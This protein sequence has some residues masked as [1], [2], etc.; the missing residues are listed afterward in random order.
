MQNN[1]YQFV[2]CYYNS[3]TLDYDCFARSRKG[4]D[5]FEGIDSVTYENCKKI[6]NVSKVTTAHRNGDQKMSVAKKKGDHGVTSL[7]IKCHR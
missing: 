4:T 2:K 1:N 7:S 3:K 5:Q 6:T